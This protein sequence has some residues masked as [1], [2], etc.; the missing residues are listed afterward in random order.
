MPAAAD[1][2]VFADLECLTRAA[3]QRFV[4]DAHAVIAARGRFIVALAGGVTPRPLYEHLARP[5]VTGQLD[6]SNVHVF[7]SDERCVPPDD[8]RSNYRMARNAWLDHIVIPEANV[9]RLRG[10]MEPHAAAAAY[11]DELRAFFG[12]A[13]SAADMSATFDLVLLGLG[14]DGH[15]ASLFPHA[16]AL[17]EQDRWVCAEY[18]AR[19]AMWRLTLTPAVINRARD[20]L[21]LVAGAR[22]AA[23][24]KDVLEGPLAPDTLPAQAIR[25]GDGRL[26]W[27]LDAAAGGR[28]QDR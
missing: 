11:D 26:S 3:A 4:E 23:R 21:F 6:W 15:T 13:R 10:E 14:E 28:L 1:V 12:V 9:H 16:H 25:P 24:V 20:V 18:V 5:D 19:V 22:K 27:F 2:H 8:D 7:W 17:T